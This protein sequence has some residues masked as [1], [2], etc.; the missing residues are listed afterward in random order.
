MRLGSMMVWL[1]PPKLVAFQPRRT[2][3][4]LIL[5]QRARLMVPASTFTLSRLW[6]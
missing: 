4:Q 6:R 2:S 3:I 1:R 5:R